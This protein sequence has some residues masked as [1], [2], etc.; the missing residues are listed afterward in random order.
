M[1]TEHAPLLS[2]DRM[3]AFVD[4]VVAIAMTLL[5]LPLMEAASEGG[6][7][8]HEDPGFGTLQFLGD[9]NGQIW[10][11]FV[12]FVLIGL[13]WVTHHRIYDQVGTVTN[14]LIWLNIL[15]MFGIICLP[16]TTALVGAMHPDRAQQFIYIGNLA[17]LQLASL[18]GR[19]YLL[20]HDNLT[21]AP[22]DA[23]TRGILADAIALTLFLIALLIGVLFPSLSYAPL[24]LLVFT[25]QLTWLVS[26]TKRA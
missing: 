6:Q 19:L 20:R 15:W 26:K 22:R 5:I 9:H 11:M 17:F 3:K 18:F 14:G 16:V 1:K 4:A 7:L 8:Q 25:G 13:A 2:A 21:D 12:S 24:F 10:A 23:I